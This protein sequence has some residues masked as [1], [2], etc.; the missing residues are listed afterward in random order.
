[1]K[2]RDTLDDKKAAGEQPEAPEDFVDDE[3]YSPFRKASLGSWFTSGAGRSTVPYVL[4]VIGVLVLVIALGSVFS[5]SGNKSYDGDIQALGDRL[6]RLE[7][8]LDE[9]EKN[10]LGAAQ[11]EDLNKKNEQLKGRFD[12][13]EAALALRMD[14]LASKMDN[15]SPVSSAGSVKPAAKPA[16]EKPVKSAGAE[17]STARI[18]EVRSGETLFSISRKYDM[19]VDALMRLNGLSKSQAIHP[20]QKL[21]IGAA[22]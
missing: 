5:G 17:A 9:M 14:V 16:Q 12:R 19:T 2:W 4:V 21:K 18:H 7:A 8:R 10:T 22:Q 1:M 15:L 3:T 20:G 11:L 13:M 6:A